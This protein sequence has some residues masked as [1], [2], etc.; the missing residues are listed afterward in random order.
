MN[1]EEI[2]NYL[3]DHLNIEWKYYGKEYDLYL[4]LTLD[5]E[6]ISKVEFARD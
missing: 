1:Q 3:K 5:G 2:K 4:C 6:V